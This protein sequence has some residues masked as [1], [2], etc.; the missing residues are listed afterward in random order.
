[1]IPVQVG[2]A[3]APSSS[4]TLLQLTN[5]AP[6]HDSANSDEDGFSHPALKESRIS[7]G[8]PH[9]AQRISNTI[10]ESSAV[11]GGGG[12]LSP[13]QGPVQAPPTPRKARGRPKGPARETLRNQQR[14]LNLQSRVV[15]EDPT[16][17]VCD[18]G[19]HSE[20]E[21]P[22]EQAQDVSHATPYLR[23]SERVQMTWKFYD[24]STGQ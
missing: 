10:E 24:A 2:E 15:Q 16:A 19:G 5:P 13:M 21:T 9:N 4:P 23:R 11:H 14:I 7:T 18:Y 20:A 17:S 22:I 3:E 6:P 12:M 8:T 1:M